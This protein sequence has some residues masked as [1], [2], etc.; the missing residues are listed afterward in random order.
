MLA[1]TLIANGVEEV[2]ICSGV[3]P[4]YR[5]GEPGHA[6]VEAMAEGKLWRLES[7]N[8]QVTM[9]NSGAP[10]DSFQTIITVWRLKP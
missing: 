9:A 7:T 6:W 2:A 4:D 1:E 10:L 8:G 5:L 3:S